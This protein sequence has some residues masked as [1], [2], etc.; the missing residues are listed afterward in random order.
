LLTS[1]GLSSISVVNNGAEVPPQIR[2]VPEEVTA[3]QPYVVFIGQMD[4]RP[5]VDA[6]EYFATDLLPRIHKTHAQ[7]KFVIVGRDPTRRVRRL[8][9]LPGVIVTGSVPEVASYLAGSAAVV[10]PFRIS[11]GIQNKML[12]A[13]AFGKPIV[14]TP[15]PA[16]AIGAIDGETML[17]AETAD[18]FVK[19]LLALFEDPQLYQRL[20][21]GADFVRKNFYWPDKLKKLEELLLQAAGTR[22]IPDRAVI[23]HAQAD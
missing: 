23:H 4:Y 7:L 19:A 8:G 17:I 9:R 10:A 6:V 5:N 11:H 13:L 12:E 16:K 14:S 21:N 20:C 22:E 15:G 2:S 3:L 18:D 1:Q